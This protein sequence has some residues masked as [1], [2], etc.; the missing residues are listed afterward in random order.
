MN[1]SKNRSMPLT[2]AMVRFADL[3][4]IIGSRVAIDEGLRDLCE[5]YHLARQTLKRIKRE[6]P[7][8]TKQV[9]EYTSLVEDLEEEIIR[10][11]LGGDQQPK[12][13]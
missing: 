11:L 10:Y 13:R 8:P 2:A 7:R 1:T 9:A 3:A 12:K 5:D 6:R 4:D